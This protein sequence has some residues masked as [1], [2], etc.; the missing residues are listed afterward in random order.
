MLLQDRSRSIE[1]VANQ[2]PSGMQSSARCGSRS[3]L[4]F[5][6]LAPGSWRPARVPSFPRKRCCYTTIQYSTVTYSIDMLADGYVSL[7]L[8]HDSFRPPLFC[9]SRC[10]L[11]F[12]EGSLKLS[13]TR[14][15]QRRNHAWQTSATLAR[16][17]KLPPP[18]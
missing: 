12:A 1:M 18:L 17:K 4:T 7:L 10:P 14:N 11:R 3:H 5:S 8:G 2:L 16:N 6:S 15:D 13:Y 9:L